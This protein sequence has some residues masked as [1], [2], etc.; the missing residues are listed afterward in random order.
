MRSG[1]RKKIGILFLAVF[2]CVAAVSFWIG[3]GKTEAVSLRAAA[4]TFEGAEPSCMDSF[5]PW[6]SGLAHFDSVLLQTGDTVEAVG[7]LFWNYWNLRFVGRERAGLSSAIL[8]RRILSSGIS[9]CVGT[10]WLALMLGEA[11]GLR[12]DAILL[13]GHIFFRVNGVNMEP[14]RS[15]YFYTDREYRQKY[16]SGPWT[17]YEFAPLYRKQ[18]LGIVAFNLGNSFLESDAAKALGWYKVAGEFFPAYPGIERNRILAM[19]KLGQSE[20]SK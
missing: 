2:A 10:T 20:K 14:N 16:A 4:C 5:A 18:F 12:I 3:A 17:G 1:K 6:T 8:P 19:K 7:N 13:P 11:R 9:A 15:G